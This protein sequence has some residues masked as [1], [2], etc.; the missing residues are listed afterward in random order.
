MISNVSVILL[1]ED[2]KQEKYKFLYKL[3]LRKFNK[4]L[5]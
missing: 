1:I 4:H 2:V 3:Y 5:N